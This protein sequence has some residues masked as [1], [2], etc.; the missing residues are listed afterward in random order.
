MLPFQE[1]EE[2]EFKVIILCYSKWECSL[3]YKYVFPLPFQCCGLD[4]GPCANTPLLC[5]MPSPCFPSL[6]KSQAGLQ[7]YHPTLPPESWDYRST[8]Q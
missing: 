8:S 7:L 2:L 5:V 4:T 6:F 3:N 1:V